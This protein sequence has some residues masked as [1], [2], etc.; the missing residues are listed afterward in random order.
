MHLIIAHH[1]AQN[2]YGDHDF[3]ATVLGTEGCRRSQT[4][5]ELVK[6]L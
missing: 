5:K 3:A 1:G 6:K 2:Y 4:H